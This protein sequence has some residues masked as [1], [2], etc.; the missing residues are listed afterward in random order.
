MFQN[1]W[2]THRKLYMMFDCRI[3]YYI[4]AQAWSCTVICISK[5]FR[6]AFC[7]FKL[8]DMHHN[9]GEL[10]LSQC[11][12]LHGHH[13]DAK[14]PLVLQPVKFVDNMPFIHM[15]AKLCSIQRLAGVRSK[16][17]T[18]LKVLIK[19]LTKI[20]NNAYTTAFTEIACKEFD[21]IS[22]Q[23]AMGR[24]GNI[25]KL[26]TKHQASHVSEL[27]PETYK[28][29]LPSVGDAEEADVHMMLA[30]KN[31][32]LHMECSVSSCKYIYFATN[33]YDV[34]Q[35]ADASS[36]SSSVHSSTVGDELKRK[37]V[38]TLKRKGCES[39]VAFRTS[40]N[41]DD[42]KKKY[43]TVY[44]TRK[45]SESDAFQE[46]LGFKKSVSEAADV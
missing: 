21:D 37:G 5:V 25:R 22:T 29:T 2:L 24:G 27:M 43:K 9:H 26:C 20:R 38:F 12:S 39:T 14:H 23:V 35:S 17:R 7:T 40:Y 3:H 1:M 33:H 11:I 10:Q 44:V 30:E 6:F 45:K 15:S 8:L 42:G 28:V 36:P 31:A 41:G 4:V 46:V 32:A 18:G 13:I 16:S 34:S 19:E